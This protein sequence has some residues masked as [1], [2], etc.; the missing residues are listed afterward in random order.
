M[1]KDYKIKI[2]DRSLVVKVLNKAVHL[3]YRLSLSDIGL[4]KN[5]KYIILSSCQE[6]RWDDNEYNFNN[7]SEDYIEISIEDFL[8]ITKA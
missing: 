6:I 3:G 1:K 7:L 5:A 2:T 4:F 8:K